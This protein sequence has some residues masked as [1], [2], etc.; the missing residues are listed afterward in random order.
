MKSI[1][2]DNIYISIIKER[3]S[4]RELKLD[5]KYMKFLYFTEYLCFP[6]YL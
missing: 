3:I 5:P 2:L 1:K 4:Y 6:Y